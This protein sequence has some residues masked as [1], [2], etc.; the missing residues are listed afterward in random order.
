MKHMKLAGIFFSS[1]LLFEP[2]QVGAQDMCCG[3]LGYE[4]EVE[5]SS[6][7]AAA[8]ISMDEGIS[9]H[10]GLV[11]DEDAGEAPPAPRP[12]HRRVSLPEIPRLQR[13]GGLHR[14]L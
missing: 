13:L 6:Y 5:E 8:E 12:R 11:F 14:A 1:T 2:L 7:S 10:D 3:E 4:S 9:G